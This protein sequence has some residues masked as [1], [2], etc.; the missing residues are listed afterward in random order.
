MKAAHIAPF[1]GIIK[2]WVA[3]PES[4][5][6]PIV[7]VLDIDSCPDRLLSVLAKMFE[8]DGIRGF[9]F[10]STPARQREVLRNAFLMHRR[11]G[12]PWA[13]ITAI[14]TM[15]GYDVI[16]ADDL[17]N[18]GIH[19]GDPNARYGQPPLNSYGGYHWA[20]FKVLVDPQKYP[21]RPEDILSMWLIINEWKPA[22][23]ICIGIESQ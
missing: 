22:R 16:I 7:T 15:L 20:M 14:K 8:I 1:D 2:K 17:T 13:I 23:S 5:I 12:T 3:D 18:T 6:K 10:A 4:D 11:R 9:G 19:Y 21:P